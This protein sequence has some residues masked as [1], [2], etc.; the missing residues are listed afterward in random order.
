MAKLTVGGREFD[1]AP[2]MLGALK[3]AAPIVDRINAS[4]APVESLSGIVHS[5]DDFIEVLAIGT[6]KI[7]PECDAAWFQENASFSDQAVILKAFHEL[8][9]ESGLAPKGEATAPAR[10]PRAKA[11][12]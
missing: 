9:Q 6:V 1:I 5:L 4:G 11:G 2:F 8:L 10:K 12:A 3:K 7:D